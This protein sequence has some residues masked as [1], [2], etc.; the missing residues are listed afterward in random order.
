MTGL[1][2]LAERALARDA[3]EPAIEF[4]GTWI[5]WGEFRKLAD[6]LAE[7]AQATG[8]DARAPV[9]FIPRNQPWAIAALFA[10][11]AQGR[12]IRMIYAFQSSAGIARDVAAIGAAVVVG[13]AA[14]F[15]PD[16]VVALRQT[17]AA[18]IAASGMTMRTV[19][20]I[21]LVEP[22][23][24]RVEAASPD[25]QMLT[26]GTTGAPKRFPLG[27]D[28]I[29]R[30]FVG[31]AT[32][33]PPH[34]DMSLPPFLLYFPLGNISGIYSTL[35]TLLRGQR[36]VLLEKFSVASWHDHL[37][38][39]RPER[40]GLPPAGVQMVLEADL[41][42]DDFT[43][44]RSIGTGAAPVD[45]T[46]QR[47]FEDRYG[48]PLL[49]SYGATEFAGSVAA[50]TP[51]LHAMWGAA[52][53]GSVGRAFAGAQ[54]RVVDAATGAELP[55]GQEGLLEVITPRIGPGW[56]RTSDVAA[57]DADG[58]LF[59]RGRAD[60]AILRGGFKLLPEVIE[61]ALLLHGSVA[62]AAVV[63]IADARLGQVP[64]AEVQ[65]KAGSEPPSVAELE[66]HLR[67]HVYA[68]HIPVAWRF[69]SDLP[70]TASLKVD[71][72]ALC[73]LFQP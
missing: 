8:A 45:P 70:R 44:L 9:A 67:G 16:V 63:G 50:M 53:F 36:A 56:I 29:A 52:K 35:P 2:E 20:G 73:G 33:V 19:V 10:L 57:I 11:I 13:A 27:F 46:V 43:C 28:T 48:V 26:S 39:F 4:D 34:M 14:D 68:T 61:R 49:L 30:H 38:R 3:S 54:L 17:K 15:T 66:A 1:P 25:I 6:Q 22:L 72:L 24:P 21:G 71:R 55:P 37:L 40:G 59:H 41:P 58:F 42:R 18:G 7:L 5:G 47:A 12:A 69:V 23:A 51:D 60:G 31:D 64:V 62:A 65:P 32:A